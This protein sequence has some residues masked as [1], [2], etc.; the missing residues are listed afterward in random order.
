M[1][2]NNTLNAALSKL[3]FFRLRNERVEFCKKGE[4]VWNYLDD[5][6][7][8]KIFIVADNEINKAKT[9][10]RFCYSDLD[11]AILKILNNGDNNR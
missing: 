1:T 3:Y 11:L 9:V 2:K 10:Y 5:S 6:S 7:R 8:E 4:S